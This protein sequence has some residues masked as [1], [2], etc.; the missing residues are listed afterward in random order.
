MVHSLVVGL[1][2]RHYP[3]RFGLRL[4][5]LFKQFRKDRNPLPDLMEEQ[6]NSTAEQVFQNSEWGDLWRDAHMPEVVQY[7]LGNTNM[8]LP[9]NWRILFPESL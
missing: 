7:L 3:P 5:K 9:R 2:L 8:D 1:G 6:M 4:L